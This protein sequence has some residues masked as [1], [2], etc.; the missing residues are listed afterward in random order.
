MLEEPNDGVF[1]DNSASASSSTLTEDKVM[2]KSLEAMLYAELSP[3]VK[4]KVVFAN[5]AASSDDILTA[6]DYPT[7]SHYDHLKPQRDWSSVNVLNEPRSILAGSADRSV[8]KATQL[9]RELVLH[10]HQEMV[11]Q[12]KYPLVTFRYY[13][14]CFFGSELIDCMVPFLREHS[15]QAISRSHIL[16]VC[17]RLLISSVMINVQVPSNTLFQEL[18]LYRFPNRPSWTETDSPVSHCIL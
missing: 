13:D 9:W 10:L 14:D 1:E 8:S 18:N 15:R 11:T 5:R 12:K 6:S 2:D 3:A 16:T 4:K 17:H 7:T